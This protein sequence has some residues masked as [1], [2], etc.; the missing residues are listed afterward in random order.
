MA[1]LSEKDSAQS[2]KV[3]GADPATGIESY[4]LSTTSAGYIR[5]SNTP[6]PPPAASVVRRTVVGNVGVTPGDDLYTITSGKTLKIQLL[7]GGA[8]NGTD[9]SKV[10]LYEDPNGDL[11]VLNEIAV[12]YVNMSTIHIDLDDDYVGNG[13]RRILMRRI[14]FSASAREIYGRWVGYEQ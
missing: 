6:A 11:S 4:Y 1:D 7:V 14:S 5:V 10:A 8:Q 12:I 3:V 13:T 2:V 9:G